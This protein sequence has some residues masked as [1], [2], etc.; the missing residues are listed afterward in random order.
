M[1]DFH[2]TLS[3][4]SSVSFS[5]YWLDI[6]HEFL[7]GPFPI[8][9][10]SLP[11]F[12][13]SRMKKEK[14]NI[15]IDQFHYRRFVFHNVFFV[16][17]T[18]YYR[19]LKIWVSRATGSNCIFWWSVNAQIQFILGSSKFLWQGIMNTKFWVYIITKVWERWKKVGTL[20]C[21]ARK[22]SSLLDFLVI[23]RVVANPRA[24]ET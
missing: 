17:R 8:C 16:N 18:L 22:N 19:H 10:S 24:L 12:S 9:F 4:I 14:P 15:C 11:Y 13:W 20:H 1:S 6:S 2:L 3:I 21:Y 7:S 5:Q 23:W